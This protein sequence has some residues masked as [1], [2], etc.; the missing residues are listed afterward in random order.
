MSRRRRKTSRR[1]R[2][3][4]MN[5]RSKGN[6]KSRARR[7]SRR[8]RLAGVNNKDHLRALKDLKKVPNPLASLRYAEIHNS[9]GKRVK[10]DLEECLESCGSDSRCK[11]K[12]IDD[13]ITKAEI[14]VLEDKEF[15]NKIEKNRGLNT[16]Q[17]IEA[18]FA[19]LGDR[20]VIPRHLGKKLAEYI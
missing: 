5:R 10:E 11:A 18:R 14:D 3:R 7:V 2:I 13:E 6:R 8:N 17:K 15:W 19:R 16:L 9:P 4:R 12:C 20:E 1:S